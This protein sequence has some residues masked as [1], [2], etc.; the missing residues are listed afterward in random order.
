[1][2]G[3]CGTCGVEEGY[4]LSFDGGMKT[5]D[6]LEDQALDRRMIIKWILQK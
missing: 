4:M 3:A 5:R 1:M 6:H 2:S